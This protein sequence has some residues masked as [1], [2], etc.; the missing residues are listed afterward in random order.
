MLV[1]RM[2]GGLGNQMFQYAFGKAL[3]LR[4]QIPVAYDMSFYQRK[5]GNATLRSFEL[6]VFKLSI[7]EADIGSF[8]FAPPPGSFLERLRFKINK[9]YKKNELVRIKESDYKILEALDDL[10]KFDLYLDGYWQDEKY[11]KPYEEA[12]RQ[13]FAPNVNIASSLEAVKPVMA[14]I[15]ERNS[16]SV[17]FRRGD[18][19]TDPTTVQYHGACSAAYYQDA[20]AYIAQR[21]INPH[22]Y[23]FSDDSEWVR[24]NVSLP[25]SYQIIESQSQSSSF[26]DMYLMSIC[27][28]NIVANS[29]FSWWGAWLNKNLQKIV[30]APQRWFAD[31]VRD[32]EKK[33]IVP[34][35]WVRL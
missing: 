23:L 7:Q 31:A 35:R 4:Y 29:T 26:T 30:V 19:I 24:E 18:Y 6:D 8:T 32:G 3:S 11:F 12:I 5:E 2:S 1:V 34:T 20:I 25:Y 21:V 33:D 14:D 27:K 13:G 16:V 28:H 9:A 22:F 17:H 15:K 10:K